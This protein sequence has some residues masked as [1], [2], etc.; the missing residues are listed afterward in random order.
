MAI[1]KEVQGFI[2]KKKK[3]FLTRELGHNISTR[4]Y[5]EF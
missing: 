5:F 3:E 1:S 4:H 2:K